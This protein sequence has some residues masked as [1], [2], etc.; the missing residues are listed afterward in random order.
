MTNDITALSAVELVDKIAKREVSA[1]EAC[2]ACLA[3]IEV[4]NPLV[5]AVCTLNDRAL[6]TAQAVDARLA[7]G[8]VARPLEGV[9]F[10]IKDILPTAGIRTTFGSLLLENDVP[11]EDA[12]CVERLKAAGGVLLGK[13]N[14]PE[15]AHDVH[16]T[17]KIFGPTRNPHDVNV[18]AGGSSGGS[19]AAAAACFA[20]ITIGTDLGG[21]IRVPCSFNG[22]AGLRPT[23]G[24]VPVYPSDF[25]WDTLVEHVVG[26]MV[27][28][29]GD[30]GLVMSVLAGPDDRDPS[31]LPD[32]RLDFI[33]AASGGA[34]L[35]GRRI[36]YAGDLNGLIPLDPEVATLCRTAAEKFA[37]LGCEVVEDC[38]DLSNLREIITGTRSFGMVG[39][40]AKRYDKHKE[41]MTEQLVNQVSVALEQDVRSIVHAERLR[42]DYWHRIRKFLETYDYIIAPSVGAPPFRLDQPLPTTVGGIEVERYYD[43]FLTAYAFSITGLPVAAVPCGFTSNGLPV[44]IQIVGRRLRDDLVLEAASAYAAA[45]PEH[46]KAPEIDLAAA[47][48]ISPAFGTGGMMG[49]P[50]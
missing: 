38:H 10:L 42:T 47:K 11:E 30:V 22:L 17:N 13:T 34:S 29:V 18:T 46:F 44:G 49:K 23:P 50:V 15:F 24:R 31:T 9:P 2:E 43:V 41:L 1:V 25:G 28:T 40:Y 36:A 35:A 8:A 3:R 7:A 16:T 12:L 37:D 5:N 33:T 6:E 20:P 45:C 32:D 4:Y 39:R 26:P 19:G 21:S 27:R 14:T 48:P